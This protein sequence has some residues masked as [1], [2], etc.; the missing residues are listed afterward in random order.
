LSRFGKYTDSNAFDYALRHCVDS[1]TAPRA[2]RPGAAA[3]GCWFVAQWVGSV[4]PSSC[5]RWLPLA[6]V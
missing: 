3:L 2:V 6:L 5:C 4:R 1:I